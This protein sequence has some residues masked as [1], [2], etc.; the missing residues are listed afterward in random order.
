M[1]FR[2]KPGGHF[3]SE[4]F[5]CKFGAGATG[6]SWISK[7]VAS[8]FMKYGRG[9]SPILEKT[10]FP[11]SRSKY[12]LWKRFIRRFPSTWRS[13]SFNLLSHSSF[14]WRGVA[15]DLSV[16]SYSSN[17][18]LIFVFRIKT[19]WWYFSRFNN[20]KN[21]ATTNLF[22]EILLH[23]VRGGPYTIF[24]IAQKE[25]FV[26]DQKHSFWPKMQN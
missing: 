8:Y 1:N 2:K 16:E 25:I 23:A 19:F 9:N 14:T 3:Q 26:A 5:R 15:H 11:T 4:K 12:F 21:Q 20:W 22:G 18:K 13:K 17:C 10:G 7:K 24:N 6:L